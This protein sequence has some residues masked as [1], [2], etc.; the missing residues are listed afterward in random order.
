MNLPVVRGYDPQ[1]SADFPTEREKNL[2]FVDFAQKWI[3][4]TSLYIGILKQSVPYNGG[5]S[6]TNGQK[7]ARQT[8]SLFGFYKF[9]LPLLGN[10]TPKKSEVNFFIWQICFWG[11]NFDLSVGLKIKT[12]RF[13]A[14]KNRGRLLIGLPQR[15]RCRA[16]PRRMRRSE[17][18]N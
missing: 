5:K 3:R 1:K 8:A 4:V 11:L 6:N 9:Y 16:K 13:D 15:G 2:R 10:I 18:L 12:N 14:I 7:N 17:G